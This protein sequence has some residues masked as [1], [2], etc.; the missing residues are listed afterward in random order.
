MKRREFMKLTG[1][2]VAGLVGLERLIRTMAGQPASA[3]EICAAPT[4]VA[5][6]CAVSTAN[7]ESTTGYG[8]G[9]GFYCSRNFSCGNNGNNVTCGNVQ[10]QGYNFSCTNYQCNSNFNCHDFQCQQGSSRDFDCRDKFDCATTQATYAQFSCDGTDL[11]GGAQFNCH[12]QFTCYDGGGQRVWCEDFWCDRGDFTCHHPFS[13]SDTNYDC[14][15][16]FSC[17][18]SWSCPNPSPYCN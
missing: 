3:S 17:S 4:N 14:G 2:G 18:P 1:V 16:N 10:Q 12:N 5:V 9:Q 8:C 15:G 11:V 13:C 7:A 6:I